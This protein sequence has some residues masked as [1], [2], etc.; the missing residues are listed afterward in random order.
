MLMLKT[1]CVNAIFNK[2]KLI[3]LKFLL[4]VTTDFLDYVSVVNHN[5]HY[6]S[7]I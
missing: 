7:T 4:S 5:M 6:V 2:K 3:H 1:N